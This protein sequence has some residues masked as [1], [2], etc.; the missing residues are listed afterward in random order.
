MASQTVTLVL[1]PPEHHSDAQNHTAVISAPASV[2]RNVR[3]EISYHTPPEDGGPQ[4]PIYIKDET[5]RVTKK[6]NNFQPVT[7]YDVRGSGIEHTLDKT[8]IQFINHKIMTKDFDDD[9]KIKEAY[10]PEIADLLYRV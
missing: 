1:S 6:R 5:T 10:Y 3:T 7:V 4:M 8:G 2:P 9:A